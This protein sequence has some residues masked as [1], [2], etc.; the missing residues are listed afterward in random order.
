M[1]KDNVSKEDMQ[2][3]QEY[4]EQ[5]DYY[6]KLVEQLDNNLADLAKLKA[7]INELEKLKGDEEILAPLANGIFIDAKLKSVKHL[8]VN[9]G[10][11]VVVKKTIPETVRLLEKQ[12]EEIARA[13]EETVQRL[14]E[15]YSALY[16]IGN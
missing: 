2:A 8:K 11:G 7:E 12:E 10:R 5:V 9:V 15:I 6:Q 4:R 3:L 16:Q 13:R 14:Q 1:T